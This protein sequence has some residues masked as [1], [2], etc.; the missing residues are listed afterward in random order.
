M[1]RHFLV[2]TDGSDLSR[3]AIDAAVSLAKSLGARITGFHVA[4]EPRLDYF[5]ELVPHN[6]VETWPWS[7]ELAQRQS[8]SYLSVISDRAA[9]AGVLCDCVSVTGTSPAEEIVKAA[10]RHG[11]DLIFLASHGRKG[12]AGLLLGSETTKVLTHCEIPVLVYRSAG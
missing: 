10:Q 4:M 1:Y 7:E 11:C 6:V 8:E 3:K 2:P 5:Q 9:Q 12:I